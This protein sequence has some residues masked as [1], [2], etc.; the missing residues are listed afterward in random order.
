[1]CVLAAFVALGLAT[2]P[3]VLS[4][5]CPPCYRNVPHLNGHGFT[6]GRKIINIY[7]DRSWDVDPSGNATPNA[8]NVNVWNGVWNAEGVQSS[9]IHMWRW[10]LS[11]F[12]D[13]SRYYPILV[14][15]LSAADIRIERASNCNDIDGK[16]AAI[17]NSGVPRRMFL[18][19]SYKSAPAANVA[20]AVAHE[21]GHALGLEH[22]SALPACSASNNT[23]MKGP[24]SP[25]T[26]I[27]IVFSVQP[28]DVWQSNQYNDNK[29]CNCNYNH[30]SF[31]PPLTCK[32]KCQN[33]ECVQDDANGT[34]TSSD[35]DDQCSGVG[36]GGCT[37]HNCCEGE[38]Q[39][40]CTW[41]DISCSCNCSPIL[42]DLS[43]NG[44]HLT[45]ASRG[46]GFDLNMDG[47]PGRV[48]WTA[49]NS[50]D[51][52][53][54][55]DR[56]NNGR[57]DDGGEL[58][59]SST[60]QPNSAYPNGFIALAEYDRPDN[61]G[62]DDGNISAQDIVYSSLRLWLDANHN[63]ISEASELSGLLS[64]GVS[65][66]ELDYKRSKKTDAYGNEFR[67]RAKVKGARGE[68]IGR[69]AWDVFFTHR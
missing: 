23:I 69:W 22:P 52:F 65:M 28:H 9:A 20:A 8:T 32:Y 33:G 1:V 27:P 7:I 38:E 37:P 64:K 25:E 53:L 40:C 31:L 45:D 55:L 19:D 30:P 29:R 39:E 35:C 59:G 12:S 13:H 44:F 58:F 4:Q 14:G 24:Q 42:I 68:Q 16:C 43:G 26:C 62:N 6:N 21:I 10:T 47:L 15:D 67:F 34:Y 56:N 11:S 2:E 36:G 3:L 49:A 17:T 48:G 18:C 60:L 63:G 5:A 66:I 57:I 50:D 51:A 54:V 61:G 46:V 41:D